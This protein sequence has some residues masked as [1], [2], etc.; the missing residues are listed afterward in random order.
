MLPPPLGETPPTTRLCPPEGRG[1]YLLDNLTAAGD[2]SPGADAAQVTLL[3]SLATRQAGEGHLRGFPLPSTLATARQTQAVNKK[4][5]T[6]LDTRRIHS[7]L[8]CGT[9][10][11]FLIVWMR[12][13]SEGSRRPV[14]P[15]PPPSGTSWLLARISTFPP[16]LPGVAETE[17]VSRPDSA[18]V[19]LLK[20][21]R[22]PHQ[23]R[24]RLVFPREAVPCFG[25]AGP[26]CL[27]PTPT[28]RT[29]S[30]YPC[31][32]NSLGSYELQEE[33]RRYRPPQV[34]SSQQHVMKEVV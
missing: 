2:G 15:A 22:W 31:T 3:G 14:L 21:R 27:P 4:Q 24:D 29:R 13:W 6:C 10:L 16:A 26:P 23:I 11:L 9:K 32:S 7:C 33:P 20:K 30:S 5:K 19:L 34:W 25:K 28:C 18:E 12:P 17:G 1:C 8:H